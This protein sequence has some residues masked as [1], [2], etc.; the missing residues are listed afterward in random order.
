V[1]TCWPLSILLALAVSARGE[2]TLHRLFSDNA[3]LQQRAKVPIWGTARDGEKVTVQFQKQRVTTIASNG[4]WRVTLKPL[5]AGGPFTLVVTGDPST[6]SGRGNTLTRTNL[7][8]GEVWI[9][10]GQSNMQ[11]PLTH[12]ENSQ[13][14]ISNAT[15]PQL[16]LFTVPNVAANEPQRDVNANW[17]ECTP[18]TVAGFSGVAY[19]FGRDLRAARRVPVGLINT[20]WGGSPAETWVP[21]SYLAADPILKPSLDSFQQAVASYPKQLEQ[22]QQAEPALTQKHAEAVAQAAAAGKPAPHPPAPPGDPAQNAHRPGALYYAMI[23]PLQPFAIRG[24]IWY[25]GESNAGRAWQY[26]TL[27]PT[28]IRAWRETWGAG[29]PATGSG[30]VFPFLFVQL[31][32]CGS[33]ALGV[34]AWAELREAQLRT[35]QTLPATAMA[36]ITDA[37]DCADIHPRRKE[38]VG[39]RLALAA[40]ALA[41]G[42][43]IESSGPLYRAMTVKSDRI[44][45]TFSHARGGLVTKAGELKGFIIARADQRFFPAKA[46]IEGDK[47]VVSSPDVPQPVAVRYGWA[48]CPDINL[49][50]QAGLPASPFRTDDFPMITQPR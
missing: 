36:V 38:P 20:S 11:W 43:R 31:A 24:A 22:Y 48:D 30:Q 45:L 41:Y 2:V 42:E 44:A 5:R 3:V 34:S 7:L 13:A 49:Y 4:Q 27:F 6:G 16:R 33:A 23:A 15:D 28:M 37:G 8:V 19:Y 9:C 21:R 29:A 1:K 50:N 40:R 18:Q 32:P 14:A 39:A 26:R 10:S 17:V 46:E 12:C 47:V 35:T 25:Q